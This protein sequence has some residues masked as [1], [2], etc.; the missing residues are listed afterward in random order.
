MGLARSSRNVCEAIIRTRIT[1]GTKSPGWIKPDWG[2]PSVL[3]SDP[4]VFVKSPHLRSACTRR[5]PIALPTPSG[6][7][8]AVGQRLTAGEA[9]GISRYR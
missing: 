5:C 2:R 8:K 1:L 7:G 3:T 6:V 4:D 9:D